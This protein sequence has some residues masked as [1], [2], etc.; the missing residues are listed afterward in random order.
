MLISINWL[1][2]YVDIP[3][4][5]AEE[6]AER[7]T[8]AGLEVGKIKYIGVPQNRAPGLTVPPSDHL[9]WDRDKLVLGRIVEVKAHP[10][11]DRLVLALVDYGG[12]AL[13]QCVTG[14]PNLYEYKGT[15]PLDPALWTVFAKE[16]AEVW[17]G[18][19]D[20]PQ[21]MVLKGRKLRG[22]YNKSMV[23]SEKE[24]GLSDD[25]EG[26][27]LLEPDMVAG[28]SAGA[29]IQ[30]VLGDVVLD[31]ELT[32]NL[33]R[34]WSIAGVAREVAALLDLP[35]RYPPTDVVMRGPAIEGRVAIDIREPELNARFT[36]ALIENL[37]SSRR[38]SGCRCGSRK[39]GCARSTTSW[40]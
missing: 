17:D 9:V 1:K 30:D 13:E 26:I 18:H 29:P 22:I 2:D 12:D 39:P 25:H 28:S 6:L 11:A 10:D 7:L 24:L 34:A 35:M 32:P 19:S 21:R 40:T 15:G 37:R 27:L 14:A 20:T 3:I 38:R 23:C 5:Q 36:L 8:L 4:P 31:I 33:A 16:G